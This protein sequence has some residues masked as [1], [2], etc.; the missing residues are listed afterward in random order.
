MRKTRKITS[1]I[2]AAT[3]ALLSTNIYAAETEKAIED[4]PLLLAD[5]CSAD[6][7]LSLDSCNT[8]F[9]L[10][11]LDLT[12]SAVD[13]NAENEGNALSALSVTANTKP[14][15]GLSYMVANQD[16]LL[17]GSF[18]T[19]T[20]I[21]W[22]W[23]NGE[24]DYTYDPDGDEITGR[25]LSGINDYVLGNVTIGDKIVGFATQ[26]TVAAQYQLNYQVVDEHGAESDALL[27]NFYV[28]A[29]DGNRR[30]ICK[31]T[32]NSFSTTPG[33]SLTFNWSGSYDPDGDS[34]SSVRVC[35]YAPNANPEF[36]TTSSKYYD[37]M[38]GQSMNLKFDTL[39]EY[40]VRFEISDDNNNW[41]N[42]VIA[43]IS[44]REASVLKN[45]TLN[46]GDYETTN[47][48]DFKWGNYLLSVEY[49]EEGSSPDLIFNEIAKY[50]IPDQ[51]KGKKFLGVNWKVTGRVETVSGTPVA[52][53]KVTITVRMPGSNFTATVNTDSSGN[54]VYQCN[55]K[56]WYDGWNS[57]ALPSLAEDGMATD[58]CVYGNHDTTTWV[59]GTT[60]TV[61]SQFSD[62]QSF[63]VTATAGSI[64][65]TVLGNKWYR[66]DGYW[67]SI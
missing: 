36:I 38:T 56:S 32:V 6:E 2:L 5:V 11:S 37:G 30:P 7:Q 48:N 67:E 60:L 17:N 45:V 40:R 28:E 61:K 43:A 65:A 22:L 15:A 53:E 24:T 14:V 31:V 33:Q 26:F 57:K 1:A 54:F 50:G 9:N 18:T 52:N 4:S 47:M 62:T 25:Y 16:T 46:T 34:L 63:D 55:K 58:W 21:Y 49:A 29:A 51:F 44:V 59:Y 64:L 10:D 3:M 19:D 27:H 12:N 35:V 41:S 42:W 13:N 23:S 39:G 8:V 66:I 20:I